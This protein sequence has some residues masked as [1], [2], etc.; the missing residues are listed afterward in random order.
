MVGTGG[1]HTHTHWAL[2]LLEAHTHTHN[3]GASIVLWLL[4]CESQRCSG[5]TPMLSLHHMPPA[6]MLDIDVGLLL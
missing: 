6:S 5:L 1:M 4:S 2:H 3:L